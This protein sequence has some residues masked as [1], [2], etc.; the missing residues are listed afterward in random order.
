MSPTLLQPLLVL[1][2][3]LGVGAADAFV[4]GLGVG[5]TGAVGV[6]ARHSLFIRVVGRQLVFVIQRRCGDAMSRV[7]STR[8][9][10]R[11]SAWSGVGGILRMA[12]VFCANELVPHGKARLK[13]MYLG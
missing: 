12:G 13:A 6:V 2:L 3:A 4:V 9:F 7:I 10:G 11:R 1:L 8:G 5:A